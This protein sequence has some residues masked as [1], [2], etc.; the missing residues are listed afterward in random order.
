[1]NMVLLYQ[2]KQDRNMKSKKQQSL[3]HPPSIPLASPEIIP[4]ASLE[5]FLTSH[6]LGIYEHV[7]KYLLFYAFVTMGLK[8]QHVLDILPWQ[9]I[10]DSPYFSLRIISM[11]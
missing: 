9:C 5:C 4:F 8:Q 1:M 7:K 3:P 10:L 6:F 11:E 2:F